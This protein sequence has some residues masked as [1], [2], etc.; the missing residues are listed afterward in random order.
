MSVVDL[1]RS[2]IEWPTDLPQLGLLNKPTAKGH[3]HF[4]SHSVISAK[5]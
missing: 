1:Q 2:E 5:A 4:R 3:V